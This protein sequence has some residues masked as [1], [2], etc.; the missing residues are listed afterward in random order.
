M[1]SGRISNL[2]IMFQKIGLWSR[3]GALSL[4]DSHIEKVNNRGTCRPK[5]KVNQFEKFSGESVTKYTVLI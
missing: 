4:N 5:C 3:Y 2:H 1:H